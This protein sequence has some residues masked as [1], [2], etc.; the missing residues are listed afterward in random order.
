MATKQIASKGNAEV[1]GGQDEL[2]SSDDVAR[3]IGCSA[4]HVF[5]LRKRGLPHYRIGDMIRFV[6]ARVIMWLE[7]CDM[8]D[9]NESATASRACQLTDIA[10]SGDED[11]AECAA[12]DLARE[13]PDAGD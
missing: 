8:P 11:N 6:P 9:A 12:S 10:A 2:W 4:R 7:S 3:F 5:N 1:I 13:F